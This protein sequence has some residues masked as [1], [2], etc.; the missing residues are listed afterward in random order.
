MITVSEFTK[1]MNIP[2][3]INLDLENYIKDCIL[4]SV[5]EMNTFTNRRLVEM[6][7]SH[8]MT[9]IITAKTEY[10]DGYDTNIIYTRNYPIVELEPGLMIELQYL[11]EDKEWQDIIKSPDTVANS[12]L[13]LEYGKIRLL[14]N[15]KFPQGIK[16]I[17]INYKSGFDSDTLPDDLKR[18]CYEKTALKFLNS[19]F[20]NFQ[21]LGI[22]SYEISNQVTRFSNK[23]INHNEVLKRYRRPVI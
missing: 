6:N 18:V 20:G 16:N 12:L 1:Y 17:K 8:D 23:E 22:E 15:Y 2:A 5:D 4:A 19:A 13:V 10:Y 21:R 7:P 11:K 9:I 3:P 14:K